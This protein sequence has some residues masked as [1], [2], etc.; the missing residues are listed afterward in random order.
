M[1]LGNRLHLVFLLVVEE[2]IETANHSRKDEMRGQW[3]Y[4]F[5]EDR[6]ET[7]ESIGPA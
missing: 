5:E 7:E 2:G 4:G 1:S 6:V 3:G